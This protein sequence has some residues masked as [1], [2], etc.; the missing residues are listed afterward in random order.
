VWRANIILAKSR[1][2]RAHLGVLAYMTFP[3]QHRAELPKHQIHQALNG[4]IKRRTDVVS[5]AEPFSSDRP[6]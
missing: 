4:K 6:Y 2:R 5:I 1:S 3:A